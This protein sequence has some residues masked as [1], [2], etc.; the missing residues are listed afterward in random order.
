MTPTLV[1]K[2]L[3]DVRLPLV[4]VAVLLGAFQLLWAHVMARILGKLSP[5]FNSLAGLG[6]LT[7]K[8]IENVLFEG[9]GKILRTIIGGDRVVLDGAMDLLSIGYVHPL[10]IILTCIWAIGRAAGAIAGEIDRGTMEL[11]LAQPLARSRLILAHLLLDGITIPV[12]C[13]S[14]W[15]GNFIG[16]WAVTPIKLEEPKIKV[17]SPS[18]GLDLEI[19]SFDV[20]PVKLGPFKMRLKDPL[21]NRA[22]R[23]GTR[24]PERMN[25]RLAIE[26]VRFGPALWLVGGLIFAVCGYTMWLSS[27]G[28]F[29]WRVLGLAV[30]VTLVQFL[31]NVLAQ[32][33][34]QAAWVRP[35]TIFYYYQPQQVILSE[36]WCVTFAEW[37]GGSPLVRLPM[38]VVL[39]GVGAIGY[40][41]ALRTLV[42]R[43]L[44]APL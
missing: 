5:F 8:D 20:G 36:D 32:M 26:P 27:A 15:A 28:R 19:D 22:L 17:S 39:Y 35:L 12:L 43:D 13:L 23:S 7:P 33:W 2:L 10:V 25:R 18:R 37:N 6:G 34:D 40:V 3:R 21:S 42:R 29:R 16:A 44:P 31:V 11:L 14:L 41:M 24:D 9:P 1:R 4:V 38:P 30:F